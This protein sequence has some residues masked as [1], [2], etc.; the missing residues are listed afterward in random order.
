MLIAVGFCVI[1][2]FQKTSFDREEELA[3]VRANIKYMH[4]SEASAADTAWIWRGT[5]IGMRGSLYAIDCNG[6]GKEDFAATEHR[7]ISYELKEAVIGST[8]LPFKDE[9]D[10]PPT[11]E[12]LL[13]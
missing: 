8:T 6:D 9:Q 11:I 3:A 2:S 4:R 7:N 10:G 1:L 13:P 5:I 12:A